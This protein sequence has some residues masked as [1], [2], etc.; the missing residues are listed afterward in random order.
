[1]VANTH[2]LQLVGRGDHAPRLRVGR[3]VGERRRWQHTPDGGVRRALTQVDVDGF[4]ALRGLRA[5]HGMPEEV[6]VVPDLP[7]RHSTHK[8]AKPFFMDFRSPLLLELLA[9]QLRYYRR[10]VVS[11]MLPSTADCWLSDRRGR[12]SSEL[13]VPLIA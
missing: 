7:L 12:Y 9:A 13:R 1:M 10:L 4:L 11:E 2:R 5:R 6:F 8:A 3:V